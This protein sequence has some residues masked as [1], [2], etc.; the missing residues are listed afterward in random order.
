MLTRSKFMK[1]LFIAALL[2]AA[3]IAQ[4]AP[5]D[6]NN[7]SLELGDKV[8]FQKSSRSQACGEI[9]ALGNTLAILKIN[10]GSEV[11]M[12]LSQLS[13]VARTYSPSAVDS[14]RE[15]RS[16]DGKKYLSARI[17]LTKTG[18]VS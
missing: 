6:C 14:F 11:S 17:L 9:T 2:V 10:D 5:V 18:S 16:R 7:Q 8:C 13:L 4:A 3:N 1:S 15:N 12:S